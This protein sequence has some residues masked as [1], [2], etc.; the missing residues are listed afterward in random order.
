[1]IEKADLTQIGLSLEG[2][3]K[4]DRLKSNGYFGELRDVYKFAVAFALAQGGEPPEIQAKRQ[5]MFAIPTVDADGTLAIAI[6][7]LLPCDE[8]PPYRWAERLAEVGVRML[9]KIE[10]DK[11]L[12]IGSLLTD[13]ESLSL[14]GASD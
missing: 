7:A 14:V 11:G 10:N 2:Q 12:D 1:M 4:L 8:I 6:R 5:T 3:A 9:S 13:V